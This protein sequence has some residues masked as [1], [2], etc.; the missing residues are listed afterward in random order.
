MNFHFIEI[1]IQEPSLTGNKNLLRCDKV[2]GKLLKHYEERGCIKS[3]QEFPPEKSRQ[4]KMATAIQ[5][6]EKRY[7]D[8]RFIPGDL[9]ELGPYMVGNVEADSG[10]SGRSRFQRSNSHHGNI[11]RRDVH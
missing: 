6:S 10:R 3:P 8:E 1:L 9:P 5:M 4:E 11:Q 7:G 2:W